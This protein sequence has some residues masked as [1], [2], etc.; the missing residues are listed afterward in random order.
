MYTHII[1][2]RDTF[3]N[4][5]WNLIKLKCVR[6][7]QKRPLIF[8]FRSCTRDHYRCEKYINRRCTP[9]MTVIIKRLIFITETAKIKKIKWKLTTR[10][11]RKFNRTCS[12]RRST[13]TFC[14]YYYYTC[15]WCEANELEKALTDAEASI[16]G[17]DLPTP[18]P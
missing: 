15:I 4:I 10:T 2:M 14:I 16:A 11:R 9:F 3:E 18:K 6:V 7:G 1:S 17:V 5:R 13:L 8:I 12:R